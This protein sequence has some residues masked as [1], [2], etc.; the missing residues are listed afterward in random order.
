MTM[1]DE[2]CP[3][4][5]RLMPDGSYN[6]H[7][8]IPATFKGKETVTLHIVCHDKLHHTFSER[9]MEHHYHTIERVL[10]HEEIEKFI[11]WVKKQPDDFY[12]HHK[13]TKD[14]KRKRKR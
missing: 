4:C 10:E 1:N 13:D 3:L 5:Q 12:A 9:E 11:K 2:T 7:H 14:R 8:L 6:E